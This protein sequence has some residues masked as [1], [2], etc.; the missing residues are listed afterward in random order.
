MENKN[1]IA[2]KLNRLSDWLALRDINE[3]SEAAL[4]QHCHLRQ[5]D[6]LILFGGSIVEGC[7]K[8]AQ[9][10]LKG[11]AKQLMIVG[12]EGHTTPTLRR[13]IHALRPEI[14]TDN[15]MEAEVIAAYFAA[16]YGIKDIIIETKST[17]CGNNVSNALALLQAKNIAPTSLLIMQD[18]SMQRRMDAGFRKMWPRET[19][20]INYASYRPHFIVE[21]GRLVL[22]PHTIRGMWSVEHYISLLMGEIPRLADNEK[23]YGP[24]G[25]GYIAHVDIP[26][27]VEEAFAFLQQ[28][29]AVRDA[30]EAYRNAL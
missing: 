22:A 19:L 28:H 20:L 18:T 23:G 5:V 10:Y 3:L 29:F 17:N 1:E 25:K 24:R 26:K 13:T 11:L 6:L 30:N 4:M 2:N 27:E 21:E 16:E 9:A 8:A 7:D 15:K 12:G 14:E